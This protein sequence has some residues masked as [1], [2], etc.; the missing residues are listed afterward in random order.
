MI[1][2]EFIQNIINTR[3]QW[4]FTAEETYEIHHILPRCMGGLPL[5]IHTHD[6][7]HPNLIWLTPREHYIA[8]KLLVEAYPSN[9]KLIYAFWRLSNRHTVTAEE[10]AV[11]RELYRQARRTSTQSAE[12][13]LK[14]SKA[15]KQHC[16]RWYTNGEDEIRATSCPEG[17]WAG[18]AT[19]IKEI[20]KKC[21]GKAL[22]GEQNGMYG[23]KQSAESNK[24]RS[25][26]SSARHWYNNGQIEVFEPICPAG[27]IKGRLKRC[28][29]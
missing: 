24:K 19:K 26:W 11:A 7:K 5:K 14:R 15:M 8:H 27:F 17:F 12:A 9:S 21:F 20:S 25:E 29:K 10:Y 2:Q 1:Y 4:G 6:I 3:G 23:K 18:R 28:Q 16:L 22:V 13:N